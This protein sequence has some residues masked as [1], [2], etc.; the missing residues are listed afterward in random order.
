MPMNRHVRIDLVFDADCPHVDEARSA[1][2]SALEDL[3]SAGASWAEW[4]R[5]SMTTPRDMRRYGS[6]TV[7]VN[8]RDVAPDDVGHAHVDG[9]ACRLYVDDAGDVSGVPSRVLILAAIRDAL[10]ADA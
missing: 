2:R 6:P 9:T 4:D 8:G 5:A 7:L 3:G 1:L 10:P